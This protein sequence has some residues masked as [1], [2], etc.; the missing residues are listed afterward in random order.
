MLK[1]DLSSLIDKTMIQQA[2]DP[3]LNLGLARQLLIN[4]LL[5]KATLLK[6]FDNNFKS[7]Y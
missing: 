6:L 4:L 2:E 1:K 3:S 5:N 7:Q